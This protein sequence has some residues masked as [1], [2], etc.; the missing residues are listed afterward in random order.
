MNLYIKCTAKPFSFLVMDTTLAPD[1][2]LRFRK[3]LIERIKTLIMAIDDKNRDEKLQY[4]IN[5]EAAKISPLWSEKIN[6]YECLTGEEI[7]PSNQRQIIEQAKFTYSPL[8]KTLEKQTEKQVDALKSLD[9]SNRIIEL[10]QLKSIFPQNQLN[11]L[12]INKLKEINQLQNII[13]S[14]VLDYKAKSWKNYA[15]SKY[16]QPIVF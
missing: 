5:R 6:K 2:L 10:H 3:N 8:G 12:I 15:L 11:Y 16:S 13:K 7:L 1:N 9:F 4:A 14:G